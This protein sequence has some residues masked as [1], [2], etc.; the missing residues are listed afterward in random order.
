MIL[1]GG[2]MQPKVSHVHA[3][4]GSNHKKRLATFFVYSKSWNGIRNSEKENKENLAV[5]LPLGVLA[6]LE[7]C[8]FVQGKLLNWKIW[9]QVGDNFAKSVEHLLTLLLDYSLIK[10]FGGKLNI[11]LLTQSP[12]GFIFGYNVTKNERDEYIEKNWSDFRHVIFAFSSVGEIMFFF[13][14]Q[15]TNVTWIRRIM[16][17]HYA[18]ENNTCRS[19]GGH[20]RMK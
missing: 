4:D 5:F 14:F 2:L 17:K 10:F 19:V 18:P 1:I 15:S 13:I 6:E 9:R 7:F 8:T 11:N 20:Q 3:F 12:I 16:A